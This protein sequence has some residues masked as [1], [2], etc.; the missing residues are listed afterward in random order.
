MKKTT[1]YLPED[2]KA[3][4]ERL[5][6]ATQR[7]EAEVIR[8]ALALYV[9]ESRPEPRFGLFSSGRPDLAERTDEILAD[10]FGRD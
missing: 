9:E 5:A 3:Q 6:A 4:I 10:G 8:T 2:L 7:S 1:L